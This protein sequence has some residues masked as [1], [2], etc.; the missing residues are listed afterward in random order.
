MKGSL[1]LVFYLTFARDVKNLLFCVFFL[2]LINKCKVLNAELTLQ[3]KQQV[4][5]QAEAYAARN[6]KSLSDMVE[7]YLLG[8]AIGAA[9]LSE[10][11]TYPPITQSLRGALAEFKDQFTDTDYKQMLEEELIKKYLQ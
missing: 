10:E 2:F 1:F 6:G 11:K 5:E 7:N 9:K 8:L 3:I 4:L